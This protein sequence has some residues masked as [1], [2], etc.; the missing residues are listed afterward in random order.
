MVQ[1]LIEQNFDT[2]TRR[3]RLGPALIVVLPVAL[4]V[5]MFFPSELTLLGI[6]VSVLVGCGGAALLAQIGRDMGKQKE[7]SLFELWNGKPTTRSLRHRDVVNASLLAMRHNKLQTLLPNLRLPTAAEEIA[8]PDKADEVYEACAT[9][10]RNKTRDKEKFNLVFEENCNYGFRRN[11]WGL[12]PVGITLSLFGLAASVTV[13]VLKLLVW[14]NSVPLSAIAC[15]IGSLILL[16]L[17]ITLFTPTW[18]KIAA[19]AYAERLLE[20]CEHL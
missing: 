11:L 16:I 1:G 12:K 17:W 5:V 6:L 3:A 9:F 19:D 2:Y 14:K 15:G 20:A 13:I 10:L 18:V 8:S 4:V 7:E